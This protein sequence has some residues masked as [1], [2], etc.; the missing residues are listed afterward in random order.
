MA[1]FLRVYQFLSGTIRKFQTGAVSHLVTLPLF[2][3]LTDH[4]PSF[5]MTP[6]GAIELQ[7]S[8]GGLF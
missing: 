5:R 3:Q 4:M 6:G 1:A 7:M 8:Q 2:F